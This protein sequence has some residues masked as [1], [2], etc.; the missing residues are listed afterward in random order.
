MLKLTINRI[1]HPALAP[2]VDYVLSGQNDGDLNSIDSYLYKDLP[3][4][5]ARIVF[6]IGPQ[7]GQSCL[8]AQGPR[9]RLTVV[10]A[11]AIQMFS[12]TLK[13]GAVKPLVGVPLSVLSDQV[14]DLVNIWGKEAENLRERMFL[15]PTLEARI[16]ILEAVLIQKAA[17]FQKMDYFVQDVARLIEKQGGR[18]SLESVF[19]RTGYTERQVLRKFDD[20]MG[21]GPKHFARIVRCRSLLDKLE[22]HE[23]QNW[24]RL[25]RDHG[26]FNRTHLAADFAKLLG[27]SPSGFIGDFQGRATFVPTQAKR[28]IIVYSPDPETTIPAG[29]KANRTQ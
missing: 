16:N 14:V 17:A 19:Q 9:L 3:N 8:F 5:N 18:G 22:V 25:A 11:N 24:T 7:P 6:K 29:S 13:P 2:Y 12:F 1:P 28:N 26:Y 10:P 21:M 23:E 27:Q 20:W 4:P 15:A